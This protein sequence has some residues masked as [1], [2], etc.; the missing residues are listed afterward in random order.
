MCQIVL[1]SAVV[2]EAIV[3]FEPTQRMGGWMGCRVR[4]LNLE[5]SDCFRL[6]TEGGKEAE[7][8]RRHGQTSPLGT[9][10]WIRDFLQRL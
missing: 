5:V 9:G 1:E 8:G 2:G 4:P 3:D 7:R 6:R 10:L